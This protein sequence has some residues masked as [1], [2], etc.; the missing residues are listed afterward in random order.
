[1]KKLLIIL[2]LIMIIITSIQIINT[3]ALYKNELTG[4]YNTLLGAW[5]I[6]VNE[7]DISSGTEVVEFDLPS[8]YIKYKNSSYIVDG[9]IAP[10]GEGYF[11]LLLD[12]TK[13]DV[14]V[15]YNI[16]LKSPEGSSIELTKVDNYFKEATDTENANLVSNTQVNTDTSA[17]KHIGIIPY[18][19][20]QEKCLN[21]VRINFK[22]TNLTSK[23]KNDTEL[24]SNTEGSNYVIPINLELLQ[25]MGED[26]NE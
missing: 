15:R 19:K 10:G 6:N 13:T 7:H 16:T 2:F 17:K 9:K 23:D 20:I 21:L 1:M 11:E 3:Y 26:I 25:Y 14:S 8:E 4:D 5:L 24:G 18:S 22:W 12:A